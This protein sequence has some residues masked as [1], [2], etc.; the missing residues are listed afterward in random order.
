MAIKRLLLSISLLFVLYCIPGVAT[1]YASQDRP[2]TIAVLNDTQFPV[3]VDIIHNMLSPVL[4]E[5]RERGICLQIQ[6]YHDYNGSLQAWSI[7]QG[8]YLRR[9]CPKSNVRIVFSNKQVMGRDQESFRRG[10][11]ADDDEF[12]G[13]TS[14]Y[15]GYIILYNCSARCLDVD[16]AGHSALQTALKHEIAHLFGAEHS[17]NPCSFMYFGVRQSY[18][19]WTP[20][21]TA[22]ILAHKHRSWFSD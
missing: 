21:V 20:D 3:D 16:A 8:P 14:E 15:F 10:E 17:T 19:E 12:A 7:D 9:L 5:Y 6:E 4:A 11:A 2:I 18:G 1:T 22:V 13:Q